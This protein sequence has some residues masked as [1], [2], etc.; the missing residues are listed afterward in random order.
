MESKVFE[1][2]EVLDGLFGVFECFVSSIA[3]VWCLV[4]AVK[5]G[6]ADVTL[7]DA[8]FLGQTSHLD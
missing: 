8:V 4:F 6:F 3:L 5:E 2:I 1:G 7:G